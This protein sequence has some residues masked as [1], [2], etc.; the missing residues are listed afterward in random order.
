MDIIFL[1]HSYFHFTIVNAINKM[2]KK[3]VINIVIINVKLV[4]H[5]SLMALALLAKIIL[6]WIRMGIVKFQLLPS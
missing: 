2:L 4:H 5:Q 3:F 6:L 1:Y